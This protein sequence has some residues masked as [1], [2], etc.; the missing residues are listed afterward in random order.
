M[1]GLTGLASFT[2]P[3]HLSIPGG[4]GGCGANKSNLSPQKIYFMYDTVAT[5]LVELG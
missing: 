3:R 2:P 5:H 4:E 1:G